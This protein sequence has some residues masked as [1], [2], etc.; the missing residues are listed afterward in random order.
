MVVGSKVDVEKHKIMQEMLDTADG[1]SE[2]MVQRLPTKVVD[3][4]SVADTGQC[5]GTEM[6]QEMEK[7]CAPCTCWTGS[8]LDWNLCLTPEMAAKLI[9]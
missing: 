5:G 6:M 9:L 2:G 4:E 3:R 8:P 1:V 7:G